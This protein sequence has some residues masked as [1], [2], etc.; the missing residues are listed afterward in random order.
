MATCRAARAQ[1]FALHFTAARRCTLW[2]IAR[3]KVSELEALAQL[4]PRA[5]IPSFLGGGAADCD[6]PDGSS[7]ESPRLVVTS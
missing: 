5:N 3:A 6:I 2:G 7:L 4:V 1:I